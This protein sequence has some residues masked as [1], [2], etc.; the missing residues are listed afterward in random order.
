MSRKILTIVIILAG[1]ILGAYFFMRSHDTVLANN[2]RGK[3]LYNQY[4]ASCHGVDGKGGGYV[5]PALKKAPPDLTRIPFE[6]G[7]F[8]SLRIHQYIAGEVTVAAHGEK[9]MPVWGMI[10]R[11]KYDNS[12]KEMDIFAI[13]RY[14]ES[15]QQ[16]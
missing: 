2:D 5:A 14:I 9:D 3:A 7:K 15:I 12:R 10:F 16:K 8:P 13:T 4:C 11:R 1:L 6:N